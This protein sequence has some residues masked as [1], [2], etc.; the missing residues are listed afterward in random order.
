MSAALVVAPTCRHLVRADG[1]PFFWLG[2]TAWELFHLLDREEAEFYLYTRATQGFTVTQAVALAEFEGLNRP[3]AYGHLPLQDNDPTRPVEAY[4]QHV[5]WIVRRANAH[6]LT[7]GFVPTWGDKWNCMWGCGPEIFTPANA[8]IFGEFLGRR[9]HDADL[10]WILGGDRPVKTEAHRA[11]LRAMAAGLARGDGGSHLMTLHPNGHCQSGDY[12]HDESWLDFNMI[13]SG[14]GEKDIANWAMLEKDARRTPAKPYMEAE[15]CYEN[16][17]VRNRADQGWFDAWD[18]RKLCWWGLLAGG[19]GHTYGCHDIWGFHDPVRK[20]RFADPRSAWWEALHFPGANQ[21]RHA[22]GLLLSRPL[23]K[24]IP[25]QQLIAGDAGAGADH[26]QAA[27]ADDGSY[28]YLYSASGRP[29]AVAVERL[30]GATLRAEWLDPRS[31]VR[32]AIGELRRQGF[33][34]FTPPTAG[35]GCD[36][37]LVLDAVA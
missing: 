17:P 8:E 28:A 1:S 22:R 3:N 21:M 23:L 32:T 35:A 34:V 20:R 26:I 29:I 33:P 31:G 6:G 27:R 15:P 25:D 11:I 19:C 9:Y 36:W 2:D 30:A 24:L 18:A 13:Q 14:H 4:F 12:V 5:D 10:V 7:V 37:V 16:H